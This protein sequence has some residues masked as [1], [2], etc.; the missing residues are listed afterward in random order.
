M[1]LLSDVAVTPETICSSEDST[2]PWAAERERAARLDQD[3]WDG[4]DSSPETVVR[5]SKPRGPQVSPPLPEPPRQRS[6]KGLRELEEVAGRASASRSSESASCRCVA[7]ALRPVWKYSKA[8]VVAGARRVVW[9]SLGSL[10][11]FPAGRRAFSART[12]P[13]VPSFVRFPPRRASRH[14]RGHATQCSVGP[15]VE[16]GV[17]GEVSGP[18]KFSAPRFRPKFP[19][20]APRNTLPTGPRG[21]HARHPVVPGPRGPLA[22]PRR[23]EPRAGRGRPPCGTQR[24]S[25]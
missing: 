9:W 16:F 12:W 2:S 14:G 8:S 11:S 19:R 1:D 21:V 17:A 7:D 15:L 20:R 4:G 22:A 23:R 5:F 18:L 25:V 24:R 6:S 10:G 13:E 3:V